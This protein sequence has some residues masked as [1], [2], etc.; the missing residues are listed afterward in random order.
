MG[1]L[2]YLRILTGRLAPDT[3]LVNLRTGKTDQGRAHLR[4]P[5][6]A[7]GGSARGDRRR[8]RGD[9]QVRRPARLRHG[10]QRRRQH[11]RRRSSSVQPIKFPTPMVPRAVEPKTREDE[12]EDLGRPGQDRRRGPDLHDPP[13]HPDARAGHLGH[14]RP[15]P[16]RDPAPAQ[17][18]LQARD[19]HA[20]PAR[21]LPRDDHRR[22]RGQPPAQE[23]DR[24]PRPVRR[25]PPARPARASA[26]RA[27]TSSTRSRG[28]R[29]PTS[30]SRPSRRACASRWTRGSSRATRSSTSRSRSSSARTTRS[31][32]RSRRSRP[33]RPPP[34]ARR[35]SKARPVLLEPIVTIEVIGPARE[36]RRHLRR[37][38]HP[39]RP[40]HR[41]GHARR[42]PAGHPGRPSRWPRCSRYATHLKSMTGGQGSFTMEFKSLRARP[43]QRPAADRRAVPEVRAG[44]RGRVI[45]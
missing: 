13:R 26:A 41:H 6:Q 30:S 36:V 3:T 22:R 2:S 1:K 45:A 20:H 10:Q 12:A 19:E 39:P 11:G 34:S 37:P 35:S 4:A 15:A 42:R 27:S 38:V 28:A 40:H 14:E 8:H 5:G 21:P 31:T 43:A 29:S 24:R 9:R 33:P 16:R 25:G 32:A 7:A 23:A 18:P 44:D 17:E